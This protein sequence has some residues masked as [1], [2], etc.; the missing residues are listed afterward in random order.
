MYRVECLCFPCNGTFSSLLYS[1]AMYVIHPGVLALYG[2]GRMTGLVLDSGD[3]VTHATPVYEGYAVP[4]AIARSD[5]CGRDLTDA[6]MQLLA[7]RGY[8]FSSTS[9]RD[10]KENFCYVASNF[11]HEIAKSSS[12]ARN[13]ELPDGQKIII[14]SER[15]RVPELL[16]RPSLM[17]RNGIGKNNAASSQLPLTFPSAGL[18]ETVCNAILDCAT[19]IHTALLANIVLAGG[20]LMKI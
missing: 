9:G 2:S 18:H 6:L 4:N 12:F 10:I 5:R 8:S 7:T 16:F 19:S 13:Y 15:F 3:G 17:W 1:P 11:E 20:K 14:D